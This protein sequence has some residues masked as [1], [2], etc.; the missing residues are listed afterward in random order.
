MI[1]YAGWEM[2]GE[3]AKIW[4]ACF[5]EPARPAKYFLNN[6]FRPENSLVWIEGD[7]IASVVYFL[8]MQ[9]CGE[10]KPLQAHYIY[11]A[12]TLPQHRS[13]GYMARLLSAAATEGAK[14]GDLYSAVLPATDA[15]YPLYEKSGYQPFFYAKT[16]KESISRLCDFAQSGSIRKTLFTWNQLNLLRGAR[17]SS[18]P[19]S[20]L[21][22]NES[23]AFAAGM[24]GVYGD[25][26]V[27]ARTGGKPAYA[28]CRRTD[29]DT[30]KVLE[31]MAEGDTFPNL[32][33]NII[34]AVPAETYEFRLPAESTLLGEEGDVQR[35]GL[36]Q[37][38]G[39]SAPQPLHAVPGA[40]Y[41]GLPLD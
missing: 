32:A 15:L 7:E 22:S 10:K 25:T 3:L 16:V 20:V 34:A 28:L 14:R 2:R 31:I 29:A 33:A 40:P 26:L 9:L 36:I 27:T 12:A 5:Q 17:L 23:F 37:Y 18:V 13:H 30:C 41:L 11:A 38:L 24:G 21:W 6:G 19:G 1:R 39:G 35:F 8:P 4:R